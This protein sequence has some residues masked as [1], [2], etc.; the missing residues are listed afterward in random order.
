VDRVA[1]LLGKSQR[2]WL[3]QYVAQHAD[4]P[5]MLMVHHTLGDEDGELLDASFL[6]TLA[7]Q[8]KHVQAIFYGHSHVFEIKKLDHVHLVNLP[9]VGYN[10]RDDQPVGW[11]SAETKSDSMTLTMHAIAGD[12]SSNDKRFELPFSA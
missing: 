7:S 12:M 5:T 3:T 8:N 10:F 9:A 6:K 11:M 2:N 1:G 4:K